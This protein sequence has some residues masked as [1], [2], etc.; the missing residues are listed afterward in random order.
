MPKVEQALT[1]RQIELLKKLYRDGKTIEVHT[2]E[3][4]Q[5][6]LAGELKITRQALSNHLKVLKELGYIRTGRGFIDLTDKA[7]ELLGE[8]KGDVFI[9]VRIE[10][11][12]RKNVYDAIKK[13]KL[14]RIYRV[15]GDIDLIVEA[16]K[17]K[18]DEILEEIASLDGVKETITHVVLESL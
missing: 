8:K 2:V 15:T 3:K 5:D 11:T 6:E 1:S 9:F 18:L 10:P 14:K 13:L 17:T 4:T 12:K 7:L 16:D